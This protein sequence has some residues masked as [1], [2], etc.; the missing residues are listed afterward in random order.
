MGALEYNRF[1]M[2]PGGCN[3]VNRANKR[4]PAA[5]IRIKRGKHK[6]KHTNK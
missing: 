2:V 4:Y 6:K 3:V 1:V 5:I